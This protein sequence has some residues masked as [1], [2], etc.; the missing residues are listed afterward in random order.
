MSSDSYLIGLSNEGGARVLAVDATA[1]AEELRQRHD[2]VGHASLVAAEGLVAA[3]LMSAYIKGEER[4]TLQVQMEKPRFAMIADVNADG[5]T[6]GRFTPAHIPA[7]THLQGAI[8]VIKHDARRELYRGVAPVEDTD[9][10]GALQ[11]YLVRSQ[12]SEGVVRIQAELDE[13]GG[14]RSARGLLV[15]KLPDQDTEIFRELFG[16]LAEAELGAVL[17]SAFGGE[18]WGFPLEV[19]ETRTLRFFCPCSRDRSRGILLGLGVE[20][21]RGLLSEQGRAEIS[22][23]FCREIYDFDAAELGGMIEQLD[24]LP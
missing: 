14:V 7:S 24:E 16:P 20:E 11:A 21:L 3:Q 12:Q 23:N 18:L 19:L 15:E 4:I 8:M 17:D 5:S 2:L 22:C 13:S 1:T 6:R 10:Q 9:F